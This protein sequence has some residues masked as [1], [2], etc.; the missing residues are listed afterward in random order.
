MEEEF[1]QPI[2]IGETDFEP[3]VVL[4]EDFESPIDLDTTIKTQSPTVPQGVDDSSYVD[5]ENIF[6]EYGRKLTKEDIVKDDR[7]M[8]VIR[9][10]LESRFTPGGILTKARR[11]VTGLGGGAIGGLSSQDYREMSD[12]KVFEIW[13]NYQRSFA[14]GQTV[15]TAN[16]IAYGMSADDSI[17]AKLGAGYLLFDQMDNAFTGEG[18]WAEMGDAIWDYGKSAVYDP[19]TILSLGIG[20]LIGFGGTKASS[21]AARRLMTKAYQQQIK[22]GVAKQTALGNV[23]KAVASTLPYATADALIGAGV[24]V[25][26]QSQ[27]IDVGVQKE[28]EAAQTALAAAGSLV[29]IPTLKGVGAS[30][31][32]FRKSDLAPQF[33]A[34]REFDQNLVKIGFEQ[35]KKELDKRVKKQVLIDSVDESFG[36]I[37]GDTRDLLAWPEFRAKANE[38]VEVR[39]EKYSD[40]EVTNAF[41]QYF[42]LG[43]PDGKTK[44][45]FQ[46]LKEAGF[47][48]H[49][50]MLEEINQ[51]TGRRIG[52][53]GVF[54]QT[55][56]YLGPSKVKQIVNKFEKDT[57]YKLKFIDEDGTVIPGSKAT[58]VS[59]AS[60]FARQASLGG[61]SLWL[62]SHLSR[63]EKAGMDIT[64]A[65]ELAGGA[66]KAVDD[67]KRTQ[68]VMSL[69]KRLLTSHLS[70][71]GANIKGFSQLVSINSLADFFTAAVNLGQAGVAKVAG[72]EG[73]VEKFMNRSYGSALG[74]VRRGVD[75]F[76]PD[77]PM[78]YADKMFELS[79]ATAEK[80]FR[81]IAGDGGVRDALS[82][83][84]L[85]KIKRTGALEGLDEVEQLAWKGADVVTKGAQTLTMV[86]VQDELTKRWAFGTN[87]NQAIMREYGMTF[88]EFFNPTKANW[89]A[90]EMS[91][92][93]F[94][95]N[96]LD[97]ATFRTLRETA[98]VNWSTL[99]GKESLI[100][101]RTWAKGVE[102]FTNRTPLGFVVP[103][104]SFL[105]TTVATMADLTGIN[106]MRFGVKKMTGQ[107]LDF[108]TREGAESLGRMAAGWSLIATGI[109]VAGGAKD[110]IENNLAYNQDIQDDGSIQDR[111]YD[112]PVSTMRLLSQIGG[113]GL[114]EDNQWNWS[115]VP[116]DLWK[117]LGVQIGGQAVRDLDEM[118]QTMVYASEQAIEGNFQPLEDMLSGSVGRVVQGF[119]R[120]LD[121]INQV[122]GMVSDAEMNPDRRQGA[123][124]QNQMLRYIENIIGGSEEGRPKRATPT[125]G[126]QF[127]PD[128][129]KQVLG[130]RTL[131][132]PNLIEKMMNAA[133]R[134]YWK[135]IR[136]DGPAEIKNKMDALAAPFFETAALEYLKK[137]PDYFRLPL[138]D[139]E[140]ILNEIGAE[141]RKNVTSVVEKGMP[142]SINVLRT[143]SG[144]N[145]KQV[146]NVMKFLQIEGE[147][148]DLLKEE[149]G[150]Q[151]LLR[152]QTLVDNYDDIFYGDL[153][154]D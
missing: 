121:P 59:L 76:S 105:N 47:T 125:R 123:E 102:A 82:D 4:D 28:Y 128:I 57:G 43:T 2:V 139:K 7:L 73:A 38:R 90:V 9:S 61:E 54:A 60:H 126:T 113:H 84:N 108:A 137:N 21:A 12:D 65:A 14:G 110:R 95:K 148:E 135:A 140:K 62:V 42:W 114:G 23:G 127:V 99:P 145:K 75:V 129:G 49:E 112:W 124:F 100:S 89:S 77:I 66:V 22:K 151:Q 53:A 85:D 67:P 122:W 50:S 52:K 11:S 6:A 103:F 91:T 93:R 119:T 94:Q 97:K 32:E 44:G 118:G 132:V 147:L 81:D 31:K 92:E 88:E 134:P 107:E 144:K 98:S 104:G 69:Y 19:S 130:N 154:L 56:K 87:L 138:K 36:L 64:D 37:K 83:F 109:F 26:Y 29:V 111:T 16:E 70:T 24:D 51:K 34:Y 141:V 78:E 115:E 80:L 63:L 55:I 71:T 150:L 17:K 39:G 3:P 5:I 72:N 133:G 106:A 86:R 33:L 143:L 41:F 48:I 20:K 8:E 116:A 74:A 46:A 27:L 58:P 35:A 13:Q 30:V 45:Y 79:P 136:F 153:N 10:N 152:I 40:D 149:D 117:E 68:Y 146:R 101:A 142:K 18:S 120:P 25:A 1:E 15:T 96:V 131:Q